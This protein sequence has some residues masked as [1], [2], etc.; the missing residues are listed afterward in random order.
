M[1]M[2]ALSIGQLARNLGLTEIELQPGVSLA[3]RT[4]D[5]AGDGFRQV[6]ITRTSDGS[7][8]EVEVSESFPDGHGREALAVVAIEGERD[9][10]GRFLVRGWL[11]GSAADVDEALMTA[12]S[13]IEVV[14][15]GE[16]L[17]LETT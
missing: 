5:I 11:G 13:H 16:G 6:A 10:S 1:H 2:S 4:R 17:Q 8:V 7:R 14:R 9:A 12:Q 15:A 3:S